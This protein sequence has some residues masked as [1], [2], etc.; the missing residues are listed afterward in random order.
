MNRCQIIA[1]GLLKA[2]YEGDNSPQGRMSAIMEQ[3]AELGISLERIYLNAKS[4]D[5]YLNSLR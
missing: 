5:I 3:F 4:E 1:N 2:W